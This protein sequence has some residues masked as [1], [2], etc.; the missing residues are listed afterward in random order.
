M[1]DEPKVGDI[2]WIKY[3]AGRQS[4]KIQSIRPTGEYVLKVF[5]NGVFLTAV[6]SRAELLSIIR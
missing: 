5:V 1:K 2:W 6:R 4:G 3:G